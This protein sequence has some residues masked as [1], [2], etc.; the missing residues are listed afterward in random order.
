[1]TDPKTLGRSVVR[2]G[3]QTTLYVLGDLLVQA[4]GMLLIP[5]YSHV[6]TTA[7]YGILGI[8][9][10][11]QK[12]LLPIFG[13]GI[14]GAIVRFYFDRKAED[15]RRQL[16]GSIWLGWLVLLVAL[17]ALTYGIG[18][19]CFDRLFAN[20]P[21]HP[22]LQLAI[23]IAALNALALTPRSLLRAR[24]K[25]GWFSFFS[26]LGFLL[27]VS[28]IIYFV[29]V[30]REGVVGSLKGQLT[31]SAVINLLYLGLMVSYIRW[32]WDWDALR[33]ALRF[34]LPLVPHLLASWALNFADRLIL[35]QNVALT[36]V[37]L[38]TLAYQFGQMLGMV[39]T[40]INRAWSPFFYRKMGEGDE[41]LISRL[42]TYYAWGLVWLGVATAI[43]A[44]PAIALLTAP[45]YHSAYELVPWIAAAYM[46]QG[47]YFLATNSILFTKKTRYLPRIT[48]SSALLNIGLN[49]W[50]VPKYGVLASAVS[51]LGGYVALFTLAYITARRLHPLPYELGRIGGG[52]LLAVGVGIVGALVSIRSPVL[53]LI[54]RSLVLLSYFPFLL[55]FLARPD[56]RALARHL[57]EK[58]LQRLVGRR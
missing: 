51:T 11:M 27:N 52:V 33:A 34:G 45:A 16:I 8:V 17:V 57:G 14:S 29:V 28:S 23:A 35:E 3:R 42:I 44:Q 48:I 15:E 1:M 37:G 41:M 19:C 32:H 47:F 38:Y 53:S 18:A 7:E 54:V 20:I 55:F 56:E 40:S 21:F 46:M 43:L 39:V 4:L 31:G 12:V 13:L 49:L 22:Y 2:L 5:I 36:L 30:R 24:E 6:L 26:I 25:A 58:G 9:N 10:T 50:L